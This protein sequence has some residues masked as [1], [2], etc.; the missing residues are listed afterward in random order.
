MTSVLGISAHH[1]DS[2]AC[3]FVDG[4]LVAA[5]E[6]ERFRRVK[7][8]A[9]FPSEAVRF[10]LDAGGLGLEDIEHVAVN[11]DPAKNWARRLRFV[12]TARPRLG[13]VVDRIRQRRRARGVAHE[14]RA[15]F[16]GAA[17]RARVHAVEHHRAHL[18]SAALVSPFD[19]CAAVSVDQF[20]D[21]A[22]AAWGRSEGS[23][24]VVE[25]AVH[26][27]HS[28][29]TFYTALTQFVG[30]PR[31]GD[32]YKLMG[33][34]AYGEPRFLVAMR[35]VLRDGADGTFALDLRYFRHHREK[36]F[37]WRSGVPTTEDL[38][39]SELGALLG[40]RRGEDE[41]V[42]DRH[43]DL[44][45]SAQARYEE[46]LF[47]L[48]AGVHRRSGRDALAL[49]GG[50][51]LNSVANGKV[52]AHTPF[53]RLYVP[54]APADAGGAIG[55]AVA[56]WH[57]LHPGD[58]GFVMR[59]ASWGPEFSEAAIDSELSGRAEL[60]ALVVERFADDAALC[61][62]TARAVAEGLVVGWFQGRMEWGPRALGNRSIVC[63]PRRAE[64]KDV[65]NAKIKRRE[66]FR[67]FAPAVLR[68]ELSAWFEADHD[69]P[70]MSEVLPVRSDQRARVPAIT[71][72]DGTGRPQTVARDACPLFHA[73]IVAFREQTGVPMVL[74][75]S[76]NEN[77]PI[78]CRPR[79]A[80]DCFLRTR[81]DVLVLGRTMISRP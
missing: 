17:L 10:C 41:P 74:S 75:T 55:A 45:A 66:P 77:E 49:A 36:V 24:L 9:G 42:G 65:L 52:L 58:R 64:M 12:L 70:F 68:E 53:R 62:A 1:G 76:F 44:A 67:P 40:P 51:A 80:I 15:A 23:R 5:A 18:A 72:V 6:E 54:P 4:A 13:T 20:G 11:R 16:P 31:F 22:S 63:D 3:L 34:A 35:Q 79:E 50:C 46:A 81:M 57:E 30:F 61:A 47:R 14:L 39:S 38:F 32:E 26:F 37:S 48:L 19:A 25:G 7:H 43:R 28:L 60:A 27:P 71:H 56:L 29:G 59:H 33:L 8:W 69:T 21:F 2:A 78:V 73:L